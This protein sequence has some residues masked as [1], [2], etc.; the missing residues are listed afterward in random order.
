MCAYMC[1]CACAYVHERVCFVSVREERGMG[2]M[3]GGRLGTERV[4][5]LH[6]SDKLGRDGD[7][8]GGGGGP[9]RCA[10]SVRSYYLSHIN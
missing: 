7:G 6:P 5:S 10:G 1:M 9:V 4:E 2:G 3:E 8:E